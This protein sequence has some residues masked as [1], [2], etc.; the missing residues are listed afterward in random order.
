[1][2]ED[3]GKTK[4]YVTVESKQLGSELLAGLSGKRL[5][6]ESQ[7]SPIQSLKSAFNT[8]ARHR[9]ALRYDLDKVD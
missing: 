7:M 6:R 5:N 1:M 8:S 3:G 4:V 9:N 2:V